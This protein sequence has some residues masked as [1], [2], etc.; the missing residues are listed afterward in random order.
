ME[1]GEEMMNGKGTPRAKRR[2]GRRGSEGIEI[3]RRVRAVALAASLVLPTLGAAAEDA[4]DSSASQPRAIMHRVFNALGRL[5][6][7]SLDEEAFGSPARRAEIER[8]LDVL[9]SASEDLDEHGRRRDAGFRNLSRSLASDIDEIRYRYQI[10]R[11][12]EARYFL[13]EAT[14][15]CVACHSR[16]PRAR[17][18]P[19]ADRLIEE[20]NLHEMS[21]DERARILVATR[22]F[23]KALATWE[24]HF[25]DKAVRPMELD[26]AGSLLDYLTIALRVVQA[27]VRARNTLETLALRDDVP[28]YLDRHI[29]TWVE[30]L[31]HFEATP[32]TQP[33]LARAR[34]LLGVRQDSEIQPF[35]RKRLVADLLASSVLL[36]LIDSKEPSDSEIAEAFFLLGVSEVRSIDGFWVPQAE[37]HFE[38]SIRTDPT[39]VRAHDAYLLLEELILVGYGG[40]S[41]LHLPVDVWSNLKELER[42]VD[43]A[44]DTTKNKD[45]NKHN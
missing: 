30:D 33:T 9:A 13:T 23:E 17:D 34:E 19:L 45:Q 32:Q 7:L 10:G 8:W 44:A 42:I 35:G 11:R 29:A 27:P 20:V 15:N 2:G 39:G 4:V 22:Q 40:S 41:G 14:K 26:I 12:E 21:P 37:F 25:A 3:M 24:R 16:L 31:K 28:R 6:P 18:F 5:L 38:A 43:R 36:R 1:D